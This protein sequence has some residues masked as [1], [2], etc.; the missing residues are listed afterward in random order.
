MRD[1]SCDC[2]VD[3]DYGDR[4]APVRIVT[5]T[6][7]VPHTC[8][9]CG[10]EIKPG[11]RYEHVRGMCVGDWQDFKTCMPCVAIRD[12]HCPCGFY[13]GTLKETIQECLG[14]DYTKLPD[15]GADEE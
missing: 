10:E 7:R 12:K 4:L 11:K 5:R 3:V 13:Y 14:F 9:E 6:A 1:L 2:S 8:C 15:Y